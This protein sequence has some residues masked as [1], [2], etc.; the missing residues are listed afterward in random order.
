M[1]EVL[2]QHKRLVLEL[3]KKDR[4]LKDLIEDHRRLCAYLESRLK[5]IIVLQSIEN[6]PNSNISECGKLENYQLVKLVWLLDVLET[7]PEFRKKIGERL[8]ADYEDKKSAHGGAVVLRNDSLHLLMIP[9]NPM[10]KEVFSASKN[11]ENYT[12]VPVEFAQTPEFMFL[13][14]F[15]AF[16]E[17]N[18]RFASPTNSDLREAERRK[19]DGLVFTKIIGNRFDADYF[20]VGRDSENRPFDVVIDLGVYDC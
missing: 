19:F 6:V 4:K 8:E 1:D 16:D 18:S 7:S 2:S 20:F 13:F 10:P 9:G 15:H 5:E 3:A 17:D 12:Y 11:F 14:H